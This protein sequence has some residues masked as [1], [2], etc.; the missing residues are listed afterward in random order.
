MKRQR[1]PHTRHSSLL[2]RALSLP[3]ELFGLILRELMNFSQ[4]TLAYEM[5]FHDFRL[6]WNPTVHSQTVPAL[7]GNIRY[8]DTIGFSETNNDREE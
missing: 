4:K 1:K 2:S 8:W 6:R 5:D 3:L 7:G